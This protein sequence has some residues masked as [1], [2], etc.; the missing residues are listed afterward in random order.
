MHKVV[1]LDVCRAINS[2]NKD[3]VVYVKVTTKFIKNLRL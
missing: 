2:D 1:A 3:E